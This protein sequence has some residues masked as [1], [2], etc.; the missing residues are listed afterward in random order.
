MAWQFYMASYAATQAPRAGD[1][2]WETEIFK[3]KETERARMK[4][5]MAA[6]CLD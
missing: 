1:D 2:C 6:L 4:E 3:E 5:H